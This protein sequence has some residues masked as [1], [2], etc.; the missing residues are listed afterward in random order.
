MRVFI[1][2]GTGFVGR[3]LTRAF[4]RQAHQVTV[5]TRKIRDD[6]D[7]PKGA[8]Y[9]EGDPKEGGKWQ[10]VVPNHDAVVNLAGSSIFRRWTDEAKQSIRESRISTTRHLVQSLSGS[11]G[12]NRTLFST[13]AIGYYGPHGGR[14]LDEE[15]P[16]GDARG[17]A[18]PHCMT[19]PATRRRGFEKFAGK[20]NLGVT[21]R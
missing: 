19:S 9:L 13:S 16:P 2:G 14:D 1:T 21:I 17:V 8:R 18:E 12:K 5:L 6:R 7:L 3:N 10:D 11:A 20:T 4:T 15:S